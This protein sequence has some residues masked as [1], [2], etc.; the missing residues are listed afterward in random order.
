[1]KLWREGISAIMLKPSKSGSRLNIAWGHVPPSDTSGFPTW[2]IVAVVTLAVLAG[3]GILIGIGSSIRRVSIL[4]QGGLSPMFVR[5]QLEAQLAQ[6]LRNAAAPTPGQ[7]VKTT[8]ERLTEL[9]SLYERGVITAEER[10]VGR[11]KVIG[12]G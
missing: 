5:E 12:G 2:L 1:M 7:P 6:N 11:A 9:E 8:E 3:H 10:A 4:R